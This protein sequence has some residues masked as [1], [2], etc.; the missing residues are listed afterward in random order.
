MYHTTAAIAAGAS[1]TSSNVSADDGGVAN[2]ITPQ[3]VVAT[4][5]SAIRN[6]NAFSIKKIA[7]LIYGSG[8]IVLNKTLAK[9]DVLFTLPADSRPKSVTT[10]YMIF[11]YSQD[12]SITFTAAVGSAGNVKVSDLPANFSCDS[13]QYWSGTFIAI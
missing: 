4:A 2:L 5:G 12:A 11:V 9:Q 8:Y 13:G 10:N 3:D 7:G 1:I 6:L